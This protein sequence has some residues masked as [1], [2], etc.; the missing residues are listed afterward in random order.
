MAKRKKRQWFKR[1]VWWN[2]I[3]QNRKHKDRLFRFFSRIR[4]TCW[5]CTMPCMTV[6]TLIWRSWR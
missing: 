1:G 3:R 6:R 4:N 2:K 5:S